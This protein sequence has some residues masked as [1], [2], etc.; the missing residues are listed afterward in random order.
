[1]KDSPE[2]LVDIAFMWLHCLWCDQGMAHVAQVYATTNPLQPAGM[3]IFDFGAD[4]MF[5]SSVIRYQQA[6]PAVNKLIQYLLQLPQPRIEYVVV[7]HQDTDHWGLLKYFLDFIQQSQIPLQVGK[8]IYGGDLWGPSAVIQINRLGGYTANRATDVV[9]QTETYS[10]YLYGVP[11]ILGQM[12]NVYFHTVITNAPTPRHRDGAMRKNGTST[13]VAIAFLDNHFILPGDATWET[14]LYA[15]NILAARSQSPFLNT[16]VMSVP[17]HGSMTTLVDGTPAA[18]NGLA[19][20]ATFADFCPAKSTVTSAGS[21]NQNRHP[22]LQVIE[23]FS[24]HV[25]G[26]GLEVPHSFVAY[27]PRINNWAEQPDTQRNIYTTVLSH[28]T[29]PIIVANWSFYRDIQGI[30]MTVFEHFPGVSKNTWG[31]DEFDD[32]QVD[33]WWDFYEDDLFLAR[34]QAELPEQALKSMPPGSQLFSYQLPGQPEVRRPVRP[35]TGRRSGPRPKRVVAR[36][37]A[38][39]SK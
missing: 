18:I 16:D 2:D 34:A 13:V 10:D 25:L 23:T 17:H 27:D 8:V 5:R 30:R 31:N 7:S 39:S 14:L 33:V 36:R 11:N 22:Y 12:G 37:A 3:A 29:N 1:M 20:A 21:E 32:G 19:L 35:P 15:N 4:Q 28:G 6:A 24:R 9:R 26:D 38:G